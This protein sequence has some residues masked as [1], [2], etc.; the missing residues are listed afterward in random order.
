MTPPG[1]NARDPLVMRSQRPGDVATTWSADELVV[2]VHVGGGVQNPPPLAVA[3]IEDVRFVDLDAPP[4]RLAVSTTSATP[5][6]SSAKTA[7]RSAR[8]ISGSGLA[9]HP[10]AI[11]TCD[12]LA[13]LGRAGAGV[14]T[15]KRTH[16]QG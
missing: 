6:S 14:K 2:G 9:C 13:I 5:C 4:A 16:G 3:Q 12:A 8:K 10:T 7:S 11:P 15:A 1:G